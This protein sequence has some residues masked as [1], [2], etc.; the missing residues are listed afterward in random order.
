VVGV[1]SPAG[2]Q[3]PVAVVQLQVAAADWTPD[4]VLEK[5]NEE[6]RGAGLPTLAAVVIARREEDYP[7]G[8]T[9]K[10]LKRELRTRHADLLHAQ[11][12]PPTERADGNGVRVPAQPADEASSLVTTAS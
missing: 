2:G 1:A 11:H 7:L 6:L 3:R 10:P 8:P 9:G 12:E 5:A 4:A